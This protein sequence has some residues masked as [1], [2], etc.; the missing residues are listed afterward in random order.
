L[1]SQQALFG[2]AI[3]IACHALRFFF[4]CRPV[5]DTSSI[6]R[7]RSELDRNQQSQQQLDLRR[8]FCGWAQGRGG[9]REWSD[10]PFYKLGNK[11][12]D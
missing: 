8:I 5:A 12:D 10:L 1:R 2:K 4:F 7:C 6:T 3:R 9:G 11:L